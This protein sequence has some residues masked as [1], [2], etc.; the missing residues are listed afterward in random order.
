[1]MSLRTNKSKKKAAAILIN[2][3]LNLLTKTNMEGVSDE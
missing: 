2:C 1:M 3:K